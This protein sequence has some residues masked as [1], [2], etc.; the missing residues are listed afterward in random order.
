MSFPESEPNIMHEHMRKYD[1]SMLLANLVNAAA[2]PMT[3]GISS[4]TVSQQPLLPTISLPTLATTA[5]SCASGTPPDAPA[6]PATPHQQRLLRK[7]RRRHQ[8]HPVSLLEGRQ[9]NFFQSKF[10]MAPFGIIQTG[11]HSFPYPLHINMRYLNLSDVELWKKNLTP[12]ART[13]L[14]H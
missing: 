3:A 13:T 11:E 5:A 12:Y 9:E 6:A 10:L 14:V 2:A 8:F 7:I 1:L 4:T